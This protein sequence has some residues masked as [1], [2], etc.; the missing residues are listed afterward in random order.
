MFICEHCGEV[1]DEPR[2][3]EERHPY[4]MGYAVEVWYECPY[5]CETGF[6]EARQCSVCGEYFA[7]LEDGLCDACFEEINEEGER[8]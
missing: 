2:K 7:V 6:E 8:V 4:G 5:C 3:Y 1:F